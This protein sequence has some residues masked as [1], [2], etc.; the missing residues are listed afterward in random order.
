MNKALICVDVQY[1]FLPGG[2]LGVPDGDQ[3]IPEL[4]AAMEDVDVIVFTRDWHPED[5]ISF[6]EGEP[7]YVDGEWPKHCVMGTDGAKINDALLVAALETDKPILL[8]HKGQE[9]DIEQYSGFEG[10]VVDFWNDPPGVDRNEFLWN[11]WLD[12]PVSLNEAL[13]SLGVNVVK[14]GGLATD[15]CVKA[16]ALSAT[17]I[18]YYTHVLV[19]ATRPV[20]FVT[21]VE[22]CLELVQNGVLVR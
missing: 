14:I 16:T 5:H 3:V 13:L 10:V 1:D 6:A 18:G 15:Y 20:N 12:K 4:I 17:R 19:K 8:V 9:R 22:A 2:A 21:G 7:L 11:D